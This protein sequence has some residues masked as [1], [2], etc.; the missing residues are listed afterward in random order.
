[1]TKAEM[2][3]RIDQLEAE[4]AQLLTEAIPALEGARDAL[5]LIVVD[6]DSQIA[7]Y[8]LIAAEAVRLRDQV[9]DLQMQ[10]IA[11]QPL[12]KLPDRFIALTKAWMESSLGKRAALTPEVD[13]IGFQ[14]GVDHQDFE[15]VQLAYKSILAA[16]AA[17]GA[18]ATM[19][20]QQEIGALLKR[21]GFA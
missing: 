10:V 20:E 12:V 15:V 17:K 3:D 14:M 8:Q 5:E 16:F 21:L 18:P 7:Q 11:L 13:L 4:N 9:A 1:M 6:R 2:Q 19:K